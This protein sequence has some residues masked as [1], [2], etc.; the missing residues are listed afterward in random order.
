MIFR[1]VFIPWLQQELDA[2]RDRV[3]NS[4]KRRDRNKVST[5]FCL[6][7]M[8][9]YNPP[10]YSHT[11]SQLLSTIL[12]K[13]SEHWISRYSFAQVTAHKGLLDYAN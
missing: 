3:N 5:Y 8:C 9:A 7:K 13:I 2:Y 6:I 11:V 1:W 4:A 12:P 10:R